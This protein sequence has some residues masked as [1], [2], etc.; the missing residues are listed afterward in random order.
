[1]STEAVSNGPTEKK[2]SLRRK[3][4]LRIVTWKSLESLT[5]TDN[6]VCP[7]SLVVP[8]ATTPFTPRVTTTSADGITWP[9]ES[10]AVTRMNARGDERVCAPATAARPTSANDANR[11]DQVTASI[12]A[13]GRERVATTSADCMQYPRPVQTDPRDPCLR[14]EEDLAR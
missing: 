12:D 10:F 8:R 9:L 3:P 6:S 5:S 11:L 4:I 1:M 13:S 2:R 14:N 7:R